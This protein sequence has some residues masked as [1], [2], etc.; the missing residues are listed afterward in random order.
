MTT[1]L[2]IGALQLKFLIDDKASDGKAT[3][4][5]MTVPEQARVPAPLS[6]VTEALPV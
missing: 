3:M 1:E 2:R 5:E 4:F 6:A